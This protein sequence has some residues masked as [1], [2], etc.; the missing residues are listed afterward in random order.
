M[1]EC[2]QPGISLVKT[3]AIFEYSEYAKLPERER[4][5]AGEREEPDRM[6]YY[7]LLLVSYWKIILTNCMIHLCF[8]IVFFFFLIV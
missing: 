7:E 3:S 6:Y 4:E 2:T 8:L 5:R 1:R